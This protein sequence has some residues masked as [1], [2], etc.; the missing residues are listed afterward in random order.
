M[1]ILRIIVGLIASTMIASSRALNNTVA[2][3]TFVKSQYITAQTNRTLI[4][5]YE[6]SSRGTP[7]IQSQYQLPPAYS[8][9]ITLEYNIRFDKDFEWVKGGKLPGIRGGNKAAFGCVQ[10]QPV[11]AWSYRLMWRANGFAEMYLY[12]QS[13]ANGTVPCGVSTKSKQPL[14]VRDKWI[15]LKMYAK[16]NSAPSRADGIAKLYVDN[17]LALS[18]TGIKFKSVAGSNIEKILFSTFYGGHDSSWSPSK[19][20]YIHIQGAWIYNYDVVAISQ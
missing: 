2:F 5:K 8:T 17:K 1:G 13:R 11:D 10:P 20:T 6:P 14:F 7:V 19:S 16:I 4:V 3:G 12:D 9:Q 18:R 15:N